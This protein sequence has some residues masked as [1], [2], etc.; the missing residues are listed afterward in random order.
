MYISESH[1]T[2]SESKEVNPAPPHSVPLN[3]Q[4]SASCTEALCI[5]EEAFVFIS[6]DWTP[7]WLSTLVS[8]AAIQSVEWNRASSHPLYTLVQVRLLFT[9]QFLL[10]PR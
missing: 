5:Q 3:L 8:K 4:I 10:S 7:Q 1:L 2:T 9:L 6:L